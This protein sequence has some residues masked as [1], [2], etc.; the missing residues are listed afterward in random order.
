MIRINLRLY[1]CYLSWTRLARNHCDLMA[2]ISE[3]TSQLSTHK[4]G[5]SSYKL[6][7]R[8]SSTNRGTGIVN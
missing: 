4:A 6:G 5:A 8:N 7:Q 1:P 3:Q 2:L